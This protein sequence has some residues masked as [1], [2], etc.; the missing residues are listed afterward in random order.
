M[1][2]EALLFS[3]VTGHRK[4]QFELHRRQTNSLSF[5]K[6][7]NPRSTYNM[8]HSRPHRCIQGGHGG[9]QSHNH[10]K[11]YN[12]LFH[13]LGDTPLWPMSEKHFRPRSRW[14]TPRAPLNNLTQSYARKNTFKTR[15]KNYNLTISCATTKNP[16]ALGGTPSDR[17]RRATPSPGAVKGSPSSIT[18]TLYRLPQ[19]H[20]EKYAANYKQNFYTVAFTSKRTL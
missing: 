14:R 9:L 19:M 13:E 7:I 5:S 18:Q 10:G 11:T 16:Y 20:K 12:K 8:T 17:R 2:S 15:Y 4:R 3:T 1:I 6:F